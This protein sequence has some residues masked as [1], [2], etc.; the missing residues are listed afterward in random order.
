MTRRHPASSDTV[1]LIEERFLIHVSLPTTTF[2]PCWLRQLK[3]LPAM[4]QALGSI[5][6]L[7]TFPGEGNGN[8]LQYSFLENPH[9]QR[10]QQGRKESDMTE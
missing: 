6:G 8:P 5:P 1:L 2:P 3:K 4:R 9:G 10:S 7:G